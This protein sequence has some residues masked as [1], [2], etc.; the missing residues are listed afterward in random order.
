MDA[1]SPARQGPAHQRAAPYPPRR[2][3]V[4]HDGTATGSPRRLGRLVAGSPRRP[5]HRGRRFGRS[6][7]RPVTASPGHRVVASAGHR[8][9]GSPRHDGHRDT[10]S[11]SP[12]RRGRASGHRSPGSALRWGHRVRPA[13]GGSRFG[14]SPRRRV[15][16][17]GHRETGSPG[18]SLRP[19]TATAGHRDTGTAT[20]GHR[21]R[22]FGGSPRCLG[23]LVAGSPRRPGHRGRR[24]GGSPRH[25]VTVAGS[26][27]RRSPGHRLRRGDRVCCSAHRTAAVPASPPHRLEVIEQREA[28][29]T[30]SMLL[31]ELLP[32]LTPLLVE[33]YAAHRLAVFGHQFG[34][35]WGEDVL[36]TAA[37][38]VGSWRPSRIPNA[39]AAGA[40]AGQ[41]LGGSDL[42]ER[43]A[44][45]RHAARIAHLQPFSCRHAPWQVEFRIPQV[46]G[47]I[48]V[49]GL[50]GLF[51][52]RADPASSGR[53]APASGRQTDVSMVLRPR[54]A[55]R[56]HEVVAGPAQ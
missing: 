34:S 21:G 13:T 1:A 51:P 5:G 20:R 39:L 3:A 22:R 8:D 17:R 49:A 12:G 46:A 9:G 29:R 10:G 33:R 41:R 45:D 44:L 19:V 4:I 2:C 40:P 11:P 42:R 25:R 26:P 53:L 14:R 7:R 56:H 50:A 27:G 16:E 18:S 37:T 48:A 54:L 31:H 36:C 6:P 28:A 52:R 30:V 35:L 15:T 23:R 43:G 38:L 32:G 55:L 47:A 24:F